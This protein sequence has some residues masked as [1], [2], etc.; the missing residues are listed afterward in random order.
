MTTTLRAL[1]LI[2]STPADDSPRPGADRAQVAVAMVTGVSAG[3][4]MV[5]VSLLGSAPIALPATAS[6]WT[7]VRTANVLLDPDTGRPVYVLGPA[8]TPTGQI[9][10]TAPGADYAETKAMRS[11]VITPDWS[12]THRAGHGW[13]HWNT[14][15][16]GGRSD[17]YQG[18]SGVSGPLRGMA[19]YGQAITALAA[20]RVIEATLSLTGNGASPGTWQTTIQA[21]SRT[22]NGP[23][24]TGGARSATITGDQATEVDITALA[25]GLLAGHG[26]A[27]VGG[28]YGGVLGT[29]SS[30]SIALTYETET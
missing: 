7:G 28:L 25:P 23:A 8:T 18:A 24:T 4:R 6:T 20:T 21:A 15:R 19:T 12:G 1:D 10:H 22:D 30:M 9:P 26:L 2:D 11:A 3:G 13:D 29:G 17:L 16:F 5:S 14:S 27:L